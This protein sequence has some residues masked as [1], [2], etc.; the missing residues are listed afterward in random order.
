METAAWLRGPL[1]GRGATATVSLAAA[2][3]T[4]DI[5][6]VKSAPLTH[7][8]PLQR[9]QTILASLN[10]PFILSSLGFEVTKETSGALF[11]N[12]FLEYA[13]GGSL[14]DDIK[15]RSDPLKEAE[16][17]SRARDILIGLAHLHNSGV[18]HCDLK[19][20][21]VL[22]GSDGRAKIGDL[23]CARWIAAGEREIRGSPMYMSPEAVRGEEQGFPADIWSFGC[24]VIEMATGR[25]PWPDV[26]DAV[27]GIN[28]IGFSGEVPV[29]PDCFSDEGRD[30]VNNCLK[31]NSTERW[32]A[33]ELL[34]HPFVE[35]SNS[36]LNCADL[37][38]VSPKSTLDLRV[39]EFN[40]GEEIEDEEEFLNNPAPGR[41]EEL[42]SGSADPNWTWDGDWEDVRKMTGECAA[43]TEVVIAVTVAGG[44][45][46]VGDFVIFD[47]DA[48]TSGG[49]EIVRDESRESWGWENG[50]DE[51]NRL[52]R[53]MGIVDSG[54]TDSLG[55]LIGSL[56]RF[57]VWHFVFGIFCLV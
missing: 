17:R 18:A 16:I 34:R 32:T 42:A 45:L 44:E 40:E 3:A 36:S 11:Y 4:G 35:C 1:V 20:G 25:P 38:W 9:E 5:F 53:K 24:T 28:R 6:A 55:F 22:I 49:E 19:P 8:A 7:S 23:G 15:R 46:G 27:E 41:I 37:S 21:N 51:L 33:D 54:V 56:L 10:S 31:M 47:E 29:I 2:A 57:L 50:D 30:F 43:E 12:L 52:R 26:T 39:W 14:A 13:G 48:S